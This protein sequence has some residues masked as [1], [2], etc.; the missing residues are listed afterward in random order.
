MAEISINDLQVNDSES[1]IASLQET[2]L[3][4]LKNAIGRAI[5]SRQIVGGMQSVKLPLPGP[6]CPFPPGTVGIIIRP[7][8]PLEK[9]L[10]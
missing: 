8:N 7:E 6:G 1:S 4:I 9:P 5:D 10:A 2:E 3:G